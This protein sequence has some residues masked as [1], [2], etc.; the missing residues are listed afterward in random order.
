[1]ERLYNN[2]LQHNKRVGKT[3]GVITFEN[4]QPVNK[5]PG[6]I[7][8]SP[9]F[10][11]ERVQGLFKPYETKPVEGLTQEKD[12]LNEA[13]SLTKDVKQPPPFERL[14]ASISE[15]DNLKDYKSFKDKHKNVLR[16]IK[17][18][19]QKS[20]IRQLYNKKGGE[21]HE[22]EYE[23]RAQKAREESEKSRLE[24]EKLNKQFKESAEKEEVQGRTPE[25]IIADKIA[26]GDKL[27]PEE[28]KIYEET[29]F[30]PEGYKYD[31]DGSLV[32]LQAPPQGKG[33]IEAKTPTQEFLQDKE[34]I[35]MAKVT[36]KGDFSA[37]MRRF[38]SEKGDPSRGGTWYEITAYE[39]AKSSYQSG[40]WGAREANLGVGGSKE[41]K[42]TIELKNP[43]FFNWTGKGEGK[44]PIALAK[45]VL[46][47][48][49]TNVLK[50]GV[51]GSNAEK[52]YA[53]LEKAISD[54]LLKQGY[55]GVILYDKTNKM[56]HPKQSFV[57]SKSI[58][59]KAELP[60]GEVKKQT[61]KAT[62]VKEST[63]ANT[64]ASELIERGL[65]EKASKSNGVLLE[66]SLTD[67]RVAT[68][69]LYPSNKNLRE[70][71]QRET[72]VDLP[73]TVNG[74]KK[75]IKDYFDSQKAKAVPTK[76]PTPKIEGKQPT[77]A[78]EPWEMTRTEFEKS[79]KPFGFGDWYMTPEGK[80]GKTK[81]GGLGS[82]RTRVYDV[83]DK[84]IGHYA[85]SE[86]LPI[87][88]NKFES[89]PSKAADKWLSKVSIGI[90]KL[91]KDNRA[92]LIGKEVYD[93]FK[94]GLPENRFLEKQS[95]GEILSDKEY[96]KAVNVLEQIENLRNTQI[97]VPV[98]EKHYEFVKR[99]IKENKPVPEEVLKDYP[100]LTKT[101][102][103]ESVTEKV[104]PKTEESK[105]I[106]KAKK[107]DSAEEFVASKKAGILST[108]DLELKPD[109][110]KKQN[111][112][113]AA[114]IQDGKVYG[115]KYAKGAMNHSD[116]AEKYKLDY[117][118]AVPGFIDKDR[119]FLYQYE[120]DLPKS[121]LTDIWNKANKQPKSEVTGQKGKQP[122]EAI[123]P[124]TIE[125]E[126]EKVIDEAVETAKE[127]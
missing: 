21:L 120:E 18:D 6:K 88:K 115:D 45:E 92:L 114:F 66:Q 42:K 110:A 11:E 34:L 96:V 48:E 97:D 68:D 33:S 28:L 94:K 2:V 35:G 57:F 106:E 56:V 101:V 25:E 3:E 79:Q 40:W 58:E 99:A 102:K 59:P 95:K 100:E 81:G 22:K 121:Q 12:L 98:N 80:M 83:N 113:G 54:E 53:K 49:K 126:S 116:I 32:K 72:G 39:G 29:Q 10:A 123:I 90:D 104:I 64:F 51:G 125:K 5:L 36:D 4:K 103:T 50:K 109:K 85:K 13:K 122:Q 60:S 74:T 7:P 84:F 19:G 37:E 26:D 38:G 8:E 76:E 89:E 67:E 111:I 73:N 112:I 118:K 119:N 105:L 108:E 70:I 63:K 44:S 14:K 24:T 47:E 62:P 20:E 43:Y 65:P 69:I 46:G 61:E 1:W 107:Y 16:E 78:K 91:R 77:S 117:K 9:L 41:F 17:N 93:K 31:V 86:L 15:L 55:D 23:K 127:D 30:A 82:E 87:Q 71:W 124:E 75:A 27:T 52:A